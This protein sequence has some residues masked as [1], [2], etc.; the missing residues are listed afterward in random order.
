MDSFRPVIEVV[1][2]VAQPRRPVI[3]SYCGQTRASR[4]VETRRLR[5]GH[6]T[7]DSVRAEVPITIV[8]SAMRT[9][10]R[11]QRASCLGL[12]A[13]LLVVAANC[14]AADADLLDSFWQSSEILSDSP[15]F[16][17]R[18]DVDVT[19]DGVPEI[20]LANSQ[21]SGT[22]GVQEWFVYTRVRAS[23]YRLLGVLAVSHQLFLVTQQR[24]PR[25]VTYYKDMGPTGS[26]VTFRLTR[27][28]FV[29]ES[30]RRDVAFSEQERDFSGWRARVHLTPVGAPFA[31]FASGSP[32]VWKH[33]LT[34]DAVTGLPSLEGLV[35]SK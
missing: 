21:K 35:I 25:I 2:L 24:P 15:G 29:R 17:L 9:M 13:A 28:G 12:L 30:T 33:L 6:G 14:T 5:G 4:S 7:W 19:G 32:P 27:S 26:V 10:T 16:V 11:R 18:M 23:Q 3:D 34:N 22:S 1:R 31:D 20:F 8:G